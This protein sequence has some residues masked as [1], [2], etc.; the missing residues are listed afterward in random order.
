VLHATDDQLVPVEHARYLATH[1]E[2]ARLVERPGADHFWPLG[3][4]ERLVLEEI[5]EFITG[6]RPS[7][8]PDRALVTLLFTDIVGSTERASELGD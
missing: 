1:I 6:T 4:A 3:E 5:T 7:R 8:E 2:G